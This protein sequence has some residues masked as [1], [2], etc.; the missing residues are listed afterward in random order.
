IVA[1]VA[2]QLA[3]RASVQSTPPPASVTAPALPPGAESRPAEA[4]TALAPTAA[5]VEPPGQVSPVPAGGPSAPADA[6]AAGADAP[7]LSVAPATPGGATVSVQA[8]AAA[9]EPPSQTVATPGAVSPP[10]DP[11]TRVAAAASVAPEQPASVPGQATQTQEQPVLGGSGPGADPT[12]HPLLRQRLTATREMLASES[13]ERYTIHLFYSHEAGPERIEAFLG[14]ATQ[15]VDLSQV[16]VL[17]ARMPKGT[18]Y[19]LFYGSYPSREEATTALRKL[20]LAYR[21]DFRLQ[22]HSLG[23]MRRAT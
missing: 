16:F 13:A 7:G 12:V 20:P 10:P 23:D 21:R 15:A 22:V 14:R 18:R 3:T 1:G 2:W 17:S 4:S 8:A 11:T 5:A 6:P 9:A 19:R